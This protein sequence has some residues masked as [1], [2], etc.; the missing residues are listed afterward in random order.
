MTSIIIAA[1]AGN[2]LVVISVFTYKPLRSVQNFYIVSLALS[3]LLIAVVVMP[4]HVLYGL[5]GKWSFGQAMCNVWV[6]CDILMCTASIL[7]LCAIA[8]D[9]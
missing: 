3:D 6:T 1:V 7:N 4:F 2:V 8:V 9:R 5:E